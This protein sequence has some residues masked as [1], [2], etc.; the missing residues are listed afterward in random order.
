MYQLATYEVMRKIE[1]NFDEKKLFDLFVDNENIFHPEYNNPYRKDGYV[2]ATNARKMIR[3]KEN[4]V[5]GDYKTAGI[6]LNIAKNNCNYTITAEN[7]EKVL[8]AIPQIEEIMSVGNNI[9][10]SEC[11]GEGTVT[12]KYT[13]KNWN[14]YEIEEDCPVCEGLGYIERE[15]QIKTGRMIPN[16]NTVVK[17]GKN[18]I[19]ATY[20]QVLLDAM[21]IIGVMEVRL[22]C[23]K[24]IINHF[25]IDRNISVL[26]ASNKDY[27]ECE[28]KLK[29]GGE[30]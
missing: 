16:P 4:A 8:S 26:L 7:I 1:Y 10:C 13:D 27:A 17:V 2:Y 24:G 18:N 23:Q 11:D 29:K 3:I 25:R 21:R 12:W 22:V 5:R 15:R 30:Q 28:L 6:T 20:L 19:M 9:K 14:D